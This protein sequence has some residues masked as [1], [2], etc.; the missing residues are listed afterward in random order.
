M[1]AN[2]ESSVLRCRIKFLHIYIRKR[3]KHRSECMIVSQIHRIQM[4]VMQKTHPFWRYLFEILG[5]IY[6][7]RRVTQTHPY[8]SQ[9]LFSARVIGVFCF[10]QPPLHPFVSYRIIRL[11]A[12]MKYRY[13]WVMVFYLCSTYRLVIRRPVLLLPV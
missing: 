13:S 10:G 12:L 2:S 9:P 7:L 1:F 6:H 5:C 3:K 11:R 8:R 4:C